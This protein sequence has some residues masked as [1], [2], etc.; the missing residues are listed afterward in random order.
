[1]AL[2]MTG[3]AKADWIDYWGFGGGYTQSPDLDV[4]GVA[5]DMQEGYNM[6]A[7]VGWSQSEEISFMADFMFTESEY[8]FSSSSLQSLSVMLNA[9]YVCNTGDFWRPYLAAGVGGVEV[10]FDRRGPFLPAPS[11]TGSGSEWA[12]GYQGM[13]GIAFDVDETHAITL[14]YRY[15]AAEDVTI[16]GQNVEYATHNIS[17]GVVFN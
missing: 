4:G 6:G 17:I 2:A 8:E 16:A 5:R 15:Q 12:F 1:M 7:F 14:G 13:A 9:M 11:P 10:N 3:V